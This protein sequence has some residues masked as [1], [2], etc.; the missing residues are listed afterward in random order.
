MRHASRERLVAKIPADVEMPDKI[1]AQLNVRQ[2]AILSAT[3]LLAAWVYLVAGERLPLPVLVAVVL[4]VIVCGCV[5]ALGRRDGLS[6]DQLALHAFTFLRRDR[7]LVAVEGQVAEP[8]AWC[9]VRGRL[10]GPLRLPVRAIREDGVMDLAD[11]GTAVVIRAGTV[12]F[13]LRT[14]AEQAALVG[15][16]AGWLNSLD[17]PLQILLQARPVDLTDLADRVER[18]AHTLA[19]PALEEAARRHAAF[20]ADLGTD[21][22]LLTRDVLIVLRHQHTDQQPL[23]K[24]RARHTAR[25]DSAAVIVTRRAEE[26]VRSLLALGVNAAALDADDT[27]DLLVR[28]LSPRRAEPVGTARPDELI[29]LGD[30]A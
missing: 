6:L 9:R 24:H 16:F 5:L 2:V 28:S 13:G 22:D 25:R 19:D 29:T 15:V 1:I 27:R 23:W 20:L 3:G 10:P 17:V 12:P 26:A 7:R 4:P 8:P 11:G 18:D 30:H 21:R 14:E